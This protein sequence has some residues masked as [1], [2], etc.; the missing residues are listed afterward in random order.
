MYYTVHIKLHATLHLENRLREVSLLHDLPDFWHVAVP[1]KQCTAVRQLPF[2]AM[3][4]HSKRLRCIHLNVSPGAKISE[5]CKKLDKFENK[6]T[7]VSVDSHQ[8][9]HLSMMPECV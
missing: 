7:A 8:I 9:V 3:V 6:R 2:L 1:A 4:K 5:M